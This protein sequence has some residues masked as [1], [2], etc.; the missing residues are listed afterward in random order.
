MGH[1]SPQSWLPLSELH[2]VASWN[3]LYSLKFD[4][5]AAYDKNVVSEYPLRNRPDVKMRVFRA[6]GFEMP[7]KLG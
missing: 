4:L 6:I 1:Q 5:Q 3:A 7:G 2:W